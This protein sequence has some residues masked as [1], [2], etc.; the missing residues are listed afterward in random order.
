MNGRREKRKKNIYWH[1]P[2]SVNWCTSGWVYFDRYTQV[3]QCR[4]AL[5]VRASTFLCSLCIFSSILLS[6]KN[7]LIRWLIEFLTR[8]IKRIPHY[9]LAS[10][11]LLVLLIRVN[12]TGCRTYSHRI[13]QAVDLLNLLD[14]VLY[15]NNLIQR[16]E[17]GRKE[18]TD[19]HRS[20]Q[21]WWFNDAYINI[22]IFFIAFQSTSTRDGKMC[23]ANCIQ[24]YDEAAAY[25]RIPPR[26][27]NDKKI[28]VI[29]KLQQSSI[30]FCI[31]K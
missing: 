30:D 23:A 31:R 14:D 25:T 16:W 28:K 24:I 18:N 10:I 21:E 3:Y 19:S 17:R 13:G 27:P 6:P 2:I 1:D 15:A 5:R 8:S 26:K 20:I 22:N 12:S 29:F 11:S 7:V 9:L 4:L